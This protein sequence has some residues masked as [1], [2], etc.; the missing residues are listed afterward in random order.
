MEK[1]NIKKLTAF[2]IAALLGA[3]FVFTGCSDTVDL[4]N[5]IKDAASD[6]TFSY[7]SSV[8]DDELKSLKSPSSS[9]ELFKEIEDHYEEN[10]FILDEET[11]FFNSDGEE[12]AAEESSDLSSSAAASASSSSEPTE[13]SDTNVRTENVLESDVVKTDGNYIYALRSDTGLLTITDAPTLKTVYSGILYDDEN[14]FAGEMYVQGNGLI[15][16]YT[17]STLTDSGFIEETYVVT[18]D[19]T[20]RAEPKK[21]TEYRQDG[22]FESARLVDNYLYIFSDYERTSVDEDTFLPSFNG[23][24][25]DVKDVYYGHYFNSV[26]YLCIGAIDLNNPAECIS[27]KAIL[28]GNSD[29]YVS[30]DHIFIS[31]S[32][33]VYLPEFSGNKT[34]IVSLSYSNG[35]IEGKA[36]G[37]VSGG[38]NDSFSID[39]YNNYLRLVTTLNENTFS[40]DSDIDKL[41]GNY[42][43][44]NYRSGNSLYILDDNLNLVSSIDNFEENEQIKSSRFIGDT[45]YFVTYEYVDPLFAIDLTDPKN[46]KMLD[47]IQLSGFSNYLH[48]YGDN[49][50]LGI[51]YETDS[52]GFDQGIKLS[53]FDIS[54][55]TNLKEVSR[56][57]IDDAISVSTDYSY[58]GVLVDPDKNIIGFSVET[59]NGEDESYESEGKYLVYSYDNANGFKQ[60]ISDTCFSNSDSTETHDTD[61]YQYLSISDLRGLYIG[62]NFF[63]T[64]PGFFIKEYNLNSLKK[65]AEIS[66]SEGTTLN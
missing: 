5:A 20:N 33:Y 35:N 30:D 14:Q 58:K 28:T 2:S 16:T 39:Y 9:D 38:I 4:I 32:D 49:L 3:S 19:I 8:Y 63:I 22:T 43:S 42:S 47:G 59:W 44:S 25:I 53:M 24:K 60:I 55:P 45:L 62:E 61:S 11:V 34:S 64:K 1:R 48:F 23:E 54:D 52:N 29:L 56:E 36:I 6:D 66:L 12:V 26:N 50:L 21:L 40:Y 27:K 41:T 10:I 13:H 37:C 51:G 31:T 7:T 65:T 46:P 17:G 57:V 15:L 18:Y